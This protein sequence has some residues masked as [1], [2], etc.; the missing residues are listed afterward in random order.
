MKNSF[1]VTG[2]SFLFLLNLYF[3]EWGIFTEKYNQVNE[4]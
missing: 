1:E 3:G 4:Q 2:S